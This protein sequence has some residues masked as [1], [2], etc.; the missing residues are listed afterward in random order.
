MIGAPRINSCMATPLEFLGVYYCAYCYTK[1]DNLTA[2]YCLLLQYSKYF[3]IC[4]F[5]KFW[6]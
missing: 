4:F 6:L 5:S 1:T 3:V 2:V